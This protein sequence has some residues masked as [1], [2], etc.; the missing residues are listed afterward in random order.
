MEWG[1]MDLL[2]LYHRLNPCYFKS[3]LRISKMGIIHRKLRNIRTP[4]PFVAFFIIKTH[5]TS[6]STKEKQSGGSIRKPS[7]TRPRDI[8]LIDHMVSAQPGLTPQV[9]GDLTHTI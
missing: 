6:W 5:K 9:I 1:K 4:P 7:E 8:T 3:L 2:V